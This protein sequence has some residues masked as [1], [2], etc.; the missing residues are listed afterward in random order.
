MTV[1]IHQYLTIEN[2]DMY[3]HEAKI[4][5]KVLTA[6]KK[7]NKQNQQQLQAGLSNVKILPKDHQTFAVNMAKKLKVLKLGI[8]LQ[9]ISITIISFN[10][11]NY[12][13][14]APPFFL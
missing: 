5:V 2:D 10:V 4:T 1:R 8:M 12:F 7:Q 14:L 9:Y 11:E 13:F 3:K 6:E